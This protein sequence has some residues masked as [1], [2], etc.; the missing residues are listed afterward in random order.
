MAAPCPEAPAP[1]AETQPPRAIDIR[2]LLRRPRQ[3]SARLEQTAVI[4]EG[5]LV[6][7]RAVTP[8]VPAGCRPEAARIW[9]LWLAPKVT[10]GSKASRHNAVVATVTAKVV[11]ER[12]GSEQALDRLVGAKVRITGRLVFNP[13]RRGE[14]TRTRGTL[15]E[16]RAV[17][18]ITPE[19]PP[20]APPPPPP[21]DKV[22]EPQPPAPPPPEEP[23]RGN[24]D[25]DGD[26]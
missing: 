8:R 2:D 7:A 14:L 6:R 24:D 21:A 4:V 23:A 10:A 19:P 11:E 18:A 12:L 9:R 16:L 25:E 15:W 3:P 5:Y 26:D 17:S 22:E 13:S 1:R 20:P